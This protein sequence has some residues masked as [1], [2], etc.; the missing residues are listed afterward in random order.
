MKFLI[1]AH[2]PPSLCRVFTAA[3]QDAIHTISLATGNETPDGKL[4]ELAACEQRVIVSKDSDFYF[5]HLLQGR[6]EK[7]LLVQ[8]GNMRLRD[9]LK[10]FETHLPEIVA[11]LENNSLV[12]IDRVRLTVHE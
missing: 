3:G 10:L 7:L 9:L 12:E 8:V 4:T 5:S 1:D 2:L 11:A 6:P